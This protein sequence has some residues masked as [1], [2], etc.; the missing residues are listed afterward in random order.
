M[1]TAAE[2]LK[3]FFKFS[4]L[5]KNRTSGL[6][7]FCKKSYKD[8]TGIYSNFTKHLK[9]AHLSEYEQFLGRETEHS[10]DDV[11]INSYDRKAYLPDAQEKQNHLHLSITKNLIVKC[12]L[13]FSFIESIGFR[14]FM[15]D[16]NIKYNPVSSR[17]IKQTIIP[18][19]TN[20]VFQKISDTLNE[21]SYVSLTI[22]GWSDRRCRS[23]LGVT[24]HIIDNKMMPQAYLLH[25]IRFK[26]PHSGE[27]IHQL[28][29]DVL[30][31]FNIK[32]KI[33]KIITDNAANMVCAYKFGLFTDESTEATTA[34]ESFGPDVGTA[35]VDDDE[36]VVL[37]DLEVININQIQDVHEDS[38]PVRVS[39]FIHSLQLCIHDGIKNRS[40]ASR[41]LNKCK[42]V[43]RASR[44]SSKIADLLEQLNKSINKM[45]ITRW[46]S[47]FL[48]IKSIVSIDANDLQTIG[49]LMN[50]PVQFSSND[51]AILNEIIDILEP[52]H[53]VSIKCQGDTIVTASMVVPAVSHL[54]SHLR[55]IKSNIRFCKKLV[56]QLQSA[57]DKRFTGI[58]NRFNNLFVDQN[59]PFN[60][61]LYFMATVLDPA[62]KFYWT[63]DLKLDPNSENRL[64]QQIIQL[65]LDEVSKEIK[66]STKKS[67]DRSNLSSP[68][69]SKK[70]KLF[71]YDDFDNDLN[72]INSLEMDPGSQLQAYLN[73]PIKSKFSEYWS[74]S[75]LNLLKKLVFRIFSVQAS[76]AP[77]ERAFSNAG[78]ILTARRTRMNEQLFKNMVFL[79][80]NQSLL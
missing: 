43:A 13:P 63:K 1:T 76:S 77:I 29:E 30:E 47:E 44:K 57:L 48:L 42:L 24:G 38:P 74:Y 62:F 53:D 70:K 17:K 32:E 26:S 41:V 25:F 73:D 78:L 60:D 31:R 59:D 36:D 49:A 5:D 20:D 51:R 19:F 4:L 33:F 3:P 28:T 68:P 46:N 8:Q 23:F 45:N 40:Y 10:F 55:D 16:A 39:C 66:I 2:R 65:I 71:H 72:I 80:V 50:E 79:R 58:I 18:T 67:F 9:R 27:H 35:L 11:E 15:K 7:K 54:I 61:P 34:E 64:K 6:C 12:N 21:S 37:E 22:D 52:F 75:Q 56:E 14:S 69:K